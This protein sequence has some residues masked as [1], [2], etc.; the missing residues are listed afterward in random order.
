M[1]KLFLFLGTITLVCLCVVVVV[2]LLLTPGKKCCKSKLQT[3]FCKRCFIIQAPLL[4]LASICLYIVSM[5]FFQT[6]YKKA[7]KS[8]VKDFHRES[9]DGLY[10]LQKLLAQE[11]IC[12]RKC[13]KLPT[14]CSIHFQATCKTLL[15]Y[16]KDVIMQ[17]NENFS[18]QMWKQEIW[19]ERYLSKANVYQLFQV[20]N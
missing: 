16:Q 6:G 4:A 3:V 5:L 13:A 10:S 19:K 1:C 12:H 15:K 18:P 14:S 8:D 9:E 20:R 17:P 7:K 2:V 11:C